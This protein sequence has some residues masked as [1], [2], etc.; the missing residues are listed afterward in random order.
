MYI[1]T[2]QD[3]HLTCICKGSLCDMTVTGCCGSSINCHRILVASLCPFILEFLTDSSNT[4][5]IL[6]DISIAQIVCLMN[7]LYT[8]RLLL[9]LILLGCSNA[10]FQDLNHSTE[11]VERPP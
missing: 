8:G 7:L 2:L 10:F 4:D 11:P 9:H 1:V 3:E 5:V 6:P